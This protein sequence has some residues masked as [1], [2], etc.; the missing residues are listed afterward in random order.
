MATINRA[1]DLYYRGIITW[2]EAFE[3]II[4]HIKELFR[5]GYISQS[6][7]AACEKQTVRWYEG[8]ISTHTLAI[9]IGMII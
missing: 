9:Y 6:E 4:D 7:A 2:T 5:S 8:E 1:S 3:M